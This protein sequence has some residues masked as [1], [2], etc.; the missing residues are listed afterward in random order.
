MF[1][2]A[3]R[4]LWGGSPLYE[5]R[6]GLRDF[7]YP[8]FSA[9]F[10]SLYS[11]FPFKIAVFL[12]MLTNFALWFIN[13]KFLREIFL[14]FSFSALE[15]RNALIFSF[16]CSYKF[17]WNN[18]MMVQSNLIVFTFCLLGV[19]HFFLKKENYAISF[20]S[21]ATSIK[22]TPIFF[23]FWVV[24]HGNLKT[25]L[26]CIGM[27]LLFIV[28]PILISGIDQGF[29]DIHFYAND[30]I[31]KYLSGGEVSMSYAN[32]ALISAIFR[33]FSNMRAVGED[34]YTIINLGQG[35]AKVIYQS[36]LVSLMLTMFG[37]VLAT[38]K[39]RDRQDALIP[40][41]LT[42]FMLL[43]SSIT[44]KAH[45]LALSLPLAYFYLVKNYLS[46]WSKKV[47]N[48]GVFFFLSVAFTGKSIIG[49]EAQRAVGGY[50]LYTLMMLILLGS[51]LFLLLVRQKR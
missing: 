6:A 18:L 44:W 40:S 21:I 12:M 23:F 41:V 20:F 10:F 42:L 22:V 26:K 50:S 38:R 11:L 43:L 25:F 33:A 36:L 46:G 15:V 16:I 47:W 45:M 9:L 49:R 32:Q 1:W 19:Y 17:Y 7:L 35:T 8:P 24:F 2:Q 39:N 5:T 27:A 14:F 37:S 3:G 13:F 30:F 28:L 34:Y 4:D 48:I 31:L 29:S 51:F